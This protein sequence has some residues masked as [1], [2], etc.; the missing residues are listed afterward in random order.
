VH[1]LAGQDRDPV[2]RLLE[3]IRPHNLSY[4]AWTVCL[5]NSWL[6]ARYPD[7]TMHTAFGDPV[8]HSLSPAHPDV[9][10][11]LLAMLGDLVSRYEVS[12]IQLESPGYMGFTH[13]YHHEI[14]GVPWDPVQEAL[15]SISFNPTEV[16][17]AL[18]AG[19]DAGSVRQRVADLLDACW[20]RGVAVFENDA[21]TADVEALFADGDFRAYRTWQDEQVISLAE[22]IRAV[23]KSANPST[24]IRH[25]AALDGSE[26]D[27]RLIATGDG[28]LCGYATLDEDASRRAGIARQHGKTMHGA[29]RAIT[30]DTMSPA[31]I[32]PRVNAWRLAGVDSIDVYNY[33][34]MPGTNWQAIAEALTGRP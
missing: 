26:A 14:I 32:G 9:R 27:N 1:S 21:P 2:E 4:T 34:L 8:I 3:A 15:M 25:F 23:V 13:G 16:A 29:I 7:T 5:H 31:D 33:G 11:Y 22:E 20:N 19:I 12:A 17:A 24:Q 28:I 30:P 10:E 18:E 6:G